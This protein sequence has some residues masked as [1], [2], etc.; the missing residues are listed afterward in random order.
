MRLIVG[1]IFSLLSLLAT[2]QMTWQGEWQGDTHSYNIEGT[3]LTHRNDGV[4]GSA[5]IYRDYT[6]GSAFTLSQ[7]FRF[8]ETPTS[9]NTFTLTLF[10]EEL[11]NFRYHYTL[12]PITNGR[13]IQLSREAHERGGSTGWRKISNHIIASY[14]FSSPLII[15]GNLLVEVHY[16]RTRGIQLQAFSPAFGL[17]QG[18]WVP[19]KGGTIVPRYTISTKFT[20]QKKLGYTYLLPELVTHEG[21]ES[22]KV[23]IVRLVPEDIG[24]VTLVLSAPVITTHAKVSCA[25]FQPTIMAGNTPTEVIVNLGTPF[26]TYSTYDFIIT[27]LHDCDGKEITLSFTVK[28][29]GES[30]G[31]TLIP[32]GIFLTEIMV[33][34]PTV[35]DLQGIKYIEIYNNTS[36]T[37]QLGQ[38]HLMYGKTKYPLP[39]VALAPKSFAILYPTSDPYPTRIATLVP[40]GQFPALS[41]SFTLALMTS[42]GVELDK[43][44]YSSRLYGEGEP[45]TGASLERITYQ[46]DSWRRC[47]HPSGGTPGAHTTLLPHQP[48]ARG[49]VIINELLLSPSSTGEKYIEL[50]NNSSEAVNLADLYLSYSN[51]EE[52]ATSTS[53]LLV[54]E[55]YLLQPHTYVVLTPYPEALTRL[56]PQ[57]CASALLERIDFPSISPTYSEIALQSHI[58]NSRVDCITYRRQWLGNTSADR[59]GYALERVSPSADGTL[60]TS[61]RRARENGRTKGLGGTPGI[62]NSMYGEVPE[63]SLSTLIE[64]PSEP[65]LTLEQVAPMLHSFST[66]ATLSIYSLTGDLLLTTRGT[67]ISPLITLLKAGATPLPSMLI[68]VDLRFEDPTRDPSLVTYRDTW[69]HTK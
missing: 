65:T 32:E 43:L 5:S 25:G 38:F 24:R 30:V 49:S 7:G 10:H 19:L 9:H 40:M 67:D 58:D 51:K 6:S 33:S 53:W 60:R 14:Y 69:L 28:T 62:K 15:W 17:W 56:Y 61:W 52:S 41:G 44:H 8:V 35:G 26:S 47:N 22:K 3:T 64:W 2:A 55:Q 23:Q 63:S 54:R 20:S 18:E 36:S 16:D 31:S 27:G 34:P 1:L 37:K 57:H 42:D 29:E 13:G 4:S 59:T 11:G 21:N 50:Y 39:M 46:P 48:I 45:K 68:V 66:V 12:S